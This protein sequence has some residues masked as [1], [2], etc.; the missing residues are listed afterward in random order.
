MSR[1]TSISLLLVF[2]LLF[3]A[4]IVVAQDAPQAVTGTAFTYQGRLIDG[5]SAANGAYDFQFAVFNALSGGTQVGSIVSVDDLTVTDGLF[6]ATLDFGNVFDGTALYLEVRVRSGASTG[7]YAT[8]APRQALTATPYASFA[9]KAANAI[10]STLALNMPWS[11][12][13][14]VPPGFAD[15]L[16]NDA[17]GGLA[18]GAGQIAKW[19]GSIWQCDT[20][21]V[22]SGSTTYSAGYGLTLSGT[23]FSVLSTTMQNRV[24]GTCTANSIT[25]SASRLPC[26]APFS[27]SFS[28]L[29]I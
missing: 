1:K 19:N 15:N 18:C 16:D 3:S 5:G 24:S 8:L 17:L 2:T 4:T 26:A 12:L 11:G 6:V 9:T 7:T 13:T 29:P 10:T 22:G 27:K 23:V 28:T 20:D 25:R 14:S 21:L